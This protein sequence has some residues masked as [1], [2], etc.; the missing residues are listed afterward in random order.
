MPDYP[1]SGAEAL[2][3]SQY[4]ANVSCYFEI[5][6]VQENLDGTA[7]ND[8]KTAREVSKSE[9][10]EEQSYYETWRGQNDEIRKAI[11]GAAKNAPLRNMAIFRVPF[12][13]VE[14]VEFRQ[15]EAG[16]QTTNTL[17]AEQSFMRAFMNDFVEKFAAYNMNYSKFKKQVEIHQLMPEKAVMA[18]L[19]NLRHAHTNY[20]QWQFERDA[21]RKEL[22]Q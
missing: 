20:L 9:E 4:G 7:P 18:E 21:S 12:C 14:L 16:E 19:A 13:D 5:Y 15:D 6:Q 17:T 11:Q 22:G 3:L 8:L 10:E 2:A 1:S